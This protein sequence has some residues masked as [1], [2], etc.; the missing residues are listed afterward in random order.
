MALQGKE[1]E[2]DLSVLDSATGVGVVVT[3]EQIDETVNALF[4]ESKALIEEQKHD[5]NFGLLLTKANKALKWADGAMVRD[6]VNSKKVTLIGEPP[7]DDGKRKKKGK[8]AKEPKPAAKAGAA[9]AED[10]KEEEPEIDISKLIGRDVDVGNTPEILAKHR[11]FTGGKVHTRFPPEPNGYLHIGHAKAIRFNFKVAEEYGGRTYLRFDDTNPCK[12]NNEFIDHINEIVS[13]LGYSPFKVT[14]SSD[15]FQELHD[16]AVELI[17]R[18]KAYVC[19]QKAEEMSRCRNEKIDSP[20]RDTSV[21]E[22][23]KSFQKMKQGRFAEGECTLRVKMNMQHDNPCMRDF[24]AYRVRYTAHPH[25]GDSWCIYPTYDFTHCLVDSLEN[26]THSLCTLEF[27]IR[28]ESYYQLL[29]DLDAYQPY[30]WEYSRLN[31]SNTVLSKRK[32]EAL[33]NKGFV[34]G[35]DDPRLHTIQGLRRRGYTPSMI[36][37]FCAKI[38]VA[39]TGNENLTSYKKLEFYAREE[40]N[41]SAPRTFAVLDPVELEV[42]NFD[43]VAEK[44]IEACIFPPDK[45]KG[46][47]MLD[48]TPHIFVDREDFSETEKK[49]FFGIMPGQVV[50]L[51]YGPFVLLEEVVKGA[52]GSIEKVKVRV[53][54]TPEKK[55]KGV[56]HWVS[57][58]HSVAS[59]VNQYSNLMTVENVLKEASAKGVDFTSF[60]NDKSL[61]VFENARVW[62][63]LADAK[64]FDRFQ[65]ERVGYFCVDMTSKSDAFGGKLVFNGIVALK[66]AAAKRA[67]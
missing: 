45:T 25:A 22:N 31:I 19:F 2:V 12:E 7:A 65:F 61:L 51:R 42:V 43:E 33:I 18:G 39:R 27:E 58:E 63:H 6:K 49:G 62:K 60:F 57:K 46:V 48:L 20:W 16:Y 44:R 10:A 13:W 15:Y 53:V 34:S 3:E 30:V 32:I 21:D 9:A 17:K 38:G 14:A 40:L 56:I 11:A 37:K 26:I 35:W 59:V 23:L 5:F 41:T 67:D 54:P 55:V 52:D 50:C 66:E 36:N 8:Q 1:F 29:K 47:N 4:E 64:E 24:V 28:R